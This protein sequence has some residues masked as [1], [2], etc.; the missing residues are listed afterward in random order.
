[1]RVS[2]APVPLLAFSLLAAPIHGQDLPPRIHDALEDWRT[3]HGAS[4]Q[5]VYSWLSNSGRMLFG[6]GAAPPF[7][8]RGEEEWQLLGRYFVLRAFPLLGVEHETLHAAGTIEL[9]LAALGTTD[10]LAVRFQQVVDGVPVRDGWVNVLFEKETGM[11]LSI[12]SQA[13]PDVVGVDVTPTTGAETARGLAQRDFAAESGVRTIGARRPRLVL[14]GRDD[15]TS[16]V[17]TLAWEVDVAGDDGE[18]ARTVLVAARETATILERMDRIH[19]SAPRGGGEGLVLAHVTED[20]CCFGTDDGSN[21]ILQPMADMT[22]TFSDASTTTTDVKGHFSVPPGVSA[23]EPVTLSFRGPFVIVANHLH[24]PEGD[25]TR[26]ERLGPGRTM[27]QL[28]PIPL[29]RDVAQANAFFRVGQMRSWVRAVNEGDAVMDSSSATPGVPYRVLVNWVLA[30]GVPGGGSGTAPCNALFDAVTGVIKFSVSGEEFGLNCPNAS[31]APLIWH[32]M[33]HWLNERYGSG[34]D[35]KGFGE[36]SADVYAMYQMDQ[37]VL[38]Y[39]NVMRSGENASS[40]CGDCESSQGCRGLPHEDGKPL[41][42]ALWKVRRNLQAE[43]GAEWGG[44]LADALFLGWM[45]AYDQGR[46]HSLIEWQWLVLDD[47]DHDITNRT[48]RLASIDAAFREQGFPG[49]H[50]PVTTVLCR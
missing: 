18:A 48:P 50:L 21:R 39:G 35:R 40:F 36:G 47:D 33:G 13:L 1:M 31:F 8:P 41:M 29:E 16:L 6:G 9:P 14:Y 15:G 49:F 38:R 37:P 17:P 23:E 4:W 22:V 43:L 2:R 20:G 5:L 42:G 30:R 12:D 24:W 19:E 45:N 7:L 25:L 44:A 46:V 3:R 10:K 27:M 32:E 11:L 28:N 26:Q 34:N